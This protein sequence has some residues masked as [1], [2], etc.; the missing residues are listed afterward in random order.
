MIG[1][2]A[3]SGGFGHLTR[4]KKFSEKWLPDA[5]IIV[6]TNNKIAFDMFDRE[7]VIYFDPAL[8]FTKAM[9]KPWF[10]LQLKEHKITD[11][12]IDTFPA[13]ML[14]ELDMSLVGH[15]NVYLLC[16]RLKW[17]VYQ[18]LIS[19]P[20]HYKSSYIFEELEPD[21]DV[22]LKEFSYEMEDVKTILEF[23]FH[24]YLSSSEL[25]DSIW[26]VCHTSLLSEVEVLIDYAHD[27][28]SL[29]KSHPRI[30]VLTDQPLQRDDVEVIQQADPIEWF[31]RAERI[32]TAAGFNTWY[33]LAPWRDKH[34]AIPFPRKF[35]DQFW[36]SRL[37]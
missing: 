4:V 16:R 30:V 28:A 33:E 8:P 19:A 23:S 12:Y 26:V 11:F 24:N 15:C 22:W 17:E 10:Q 7:Q 2:Y 32:F 13:G 9:L 31:S 21:H 6:F 29:E 37:D 20:L 1:F 18:P 3:F 36:R 25:C 14:G 5:S 27:L 35:D 34:T